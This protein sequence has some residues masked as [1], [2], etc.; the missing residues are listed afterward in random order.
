MLYLTIDDTALPFRKN[1]CLTLARP[2][3][4]AESVLLP[5]PLES[6]APD[7]SAAHFYGTVLA[8]GGRFRMWYYACHWGVN[9]DWPPF[10]ARQVAKPPPW[11]GT[12]F[13]V[14][15]GPICYAESDDGIVWTKPALGQV[16]FKGSRGSN[17]IALPHTVVAS[18]TVIRDDEDPDTARR[19]KMVYQYFPDQ[20]DPPIEEYGA[21]PTVA[22]AVSG[23]GIAWKPAGI[24]FRGQFVEHS[25]F[26]SH[27]GRYILHYHV[28]DDWSGYFG[29]S[30][31]KCGRTGVARVTADFANWPDLIADAFALPEPDDDAVRGMN[32]SYDQVH[33]G[34]GAAS[35]GNVCVGLHGLWHN[36]D[37]TR[38]FD[39]ISGDLGLL[40]SNDGVHFREPV[41]GHRFIRRQ[42]SPATPV[43]GRSLNT[44]LCQANGIL[45]VGGET[46]IYHGR[47]RN[48]GNADAGDMKYY[49]G[50]VALATIGRD[51]W[52]SLGLNPGASEGV[53]VSDVFTVGVNAPSITLNADGCAGLAIDLLDDRFA[54][55]SGFADG[56]VDESEGLD[57]PVS[58]PGRHPGELAGKPVRVRVRLRRSDGVEPKLYALNVRCS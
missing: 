51:R 41:K 34:V 42:D 37:F 46:R 56:A 8:D 5:S 17:A 50:E 57:C 33:L 30:G 10:L 27:N 2:R 9:P 20:T 58:W 54:P 39:E 4:R 53:V 45:N 32:G 35:F 19:Y 18:P 23:D 40:V 47:W 21:T 28:M 43:P 44:I 3:V 38:G 52:G 6:D 25:S 55:L 49:S 12:E 22:L 26:I 7:N 24:P 15:Q 29:E 1:V 36:A 14:T 13:P 16:L 31:R 48:A 11:A